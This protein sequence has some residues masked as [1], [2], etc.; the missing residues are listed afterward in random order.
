MSDEIG[1]KLAVLIDAKISLCG[2]HD[3]LSMYSEYAIQT[4][5]SKQGITG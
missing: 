1:K 2:S 5:Y 4:T 3:A